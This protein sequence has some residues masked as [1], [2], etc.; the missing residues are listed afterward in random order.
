M[1]G[2]DYKSIDV[3]KATLP[4]MY[5]NSEKYFEDGVQP[6]EVEDLELGDLLDDNKKTDFE[7]KDIKS[8]GEGIS[9]V[10]KIGEPVEPR[11]DAD[12]AENIV[13]K[14]EYM[15]IDGDYEKVID[16]FGG[17]HDNYGL[18][19][20]HNGECDNY[21]RGY[22]IYLQTGQIVPFGEMTKTADGMAVEHYFANSRKEQAEFAFKMIKEEGKPCIIHVNSG[23]DGSGK[24]HWL[25]VVG[26]KKG[27]TEENVTIGDLIV[28]DSDGQ[29]DQPI[30]AKVRPVSEDSYYCMD[31]FDRCSYK[32]GYQIYYYS[33]EK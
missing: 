18:Y 24:G 2:F 11:F 13:D 21:A 15:G 29:K 1:S 22:A 14:G 7:E 30:T 25:C 31:G 27:V 6:V 9:K 8:H 32:P 5:K 17:Q 20:Y 4:K 23:H 26:Y 33:E 28:I 10:N 12:T 16:I 3:E 19:G